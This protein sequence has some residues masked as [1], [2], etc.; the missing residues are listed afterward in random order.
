MGKRSSFDRIERDFY[1][2]PIAAV[3]PLVNHLPETPFT[4]AE[5]SAGDGAL[6][7]HISKLTAGKCIYASDI[8]PQ[9]EDIKQKDMFAVCELD[10]KDV[11]YVIMN[12]PWN[13]KIL[14]PL[15]E[16]FSAIRPTWLLFDANW[17]FTKQAKPYL[18]RCVKIVTIGRVKWIEDSKM[19]GK[20]DSAWFLFDKNINSI[21]EFYGR[22]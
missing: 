21:T 2:T 3:T 11:D 13:R 19:S 7:D 16:H 6:M 5:M 20:D 8:H 22:M 4:Y 12:P 15:I 17:S 10:L 14:H 18:E 9:R 1:R